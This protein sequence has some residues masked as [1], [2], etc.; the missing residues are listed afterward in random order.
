MSFTPEEEVGIIH[1][2]TQ[3]NLVQRV[4]IEIVDD[5]EKVE[6]QHWK[7][8]NR[9]KCSINKNTAYDVREFLRAEGMQINWSDVQCNEKH[10][11]HC[12]TSLQLLTNTF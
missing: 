7:V 5:H 8:T 1:V 3:W 11:R 2:E 12:I 6:G 4:G 9:L 10:Y